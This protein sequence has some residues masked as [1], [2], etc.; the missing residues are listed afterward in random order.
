M[1]EP[2]EDMP[3]GTLGFRAEGEVTESDYT[4]VLGPALREAVDNGGVRLLLVTPPGFSSGEIAH[5]AK[6]VQELP[7]L[8]HRSDWKRVAVITSSG[9]LRRTARVWAPMV[10]V[11]TRVFKPD[12]EPAARDWLL[13]A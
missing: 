12:E 2:I 13:E 4:D 10:P 9:M 8:G 6:H 1:V 11:E 7:G 5:V 3:A